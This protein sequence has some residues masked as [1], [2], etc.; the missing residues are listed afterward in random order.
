M[1]THK[2]EEDD[3]DADWE[4]HFEDEEFEDAQSE[5]A[6]KT[7]DDHDEEDTEDEAK[8]D[9][10]AEEHETHEDRIKTVTRNQVLSRQQLSQCKWQKR[11][12]PKGSVCYHRVLL[13]RANQFAE[14]YT[15]ATCNDRWPRCGT[16]EIIRGS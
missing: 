4:L 8:E 15:C 1:L 16:S 12:L 3:D 11:F 6:N 5:E 7:E 13:P 2:D 9:D 14:W 10:T